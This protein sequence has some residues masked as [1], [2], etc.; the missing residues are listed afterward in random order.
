MTLN[1]KQRYV[2]K[3]I[4]FLLIS[5]HDTEKISPKDTIPVAEELLKQLKRMGK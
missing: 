2:L 5:L 3:K 1:E 4:S